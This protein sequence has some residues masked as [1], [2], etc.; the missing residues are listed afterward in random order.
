MPLK[1]LVLHLWQLEMNGLY[2]SSLE[3]L[4]VVI[5]SAGVYNAPE[6]GS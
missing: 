4:H 5:V 6:K 2:E 1:D 3:A